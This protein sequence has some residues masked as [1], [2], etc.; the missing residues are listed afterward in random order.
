MESVTDSESG[1]TATLVR[2]M[3][4]SWN[5]GPLML[6]YPTYSGTMFKLGEHGTFSGMVFHAHPSIPSIFINGSNTYFCMGGF[7]PLGT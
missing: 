5:E 7:R 6:S 1:M 2:A 4:D 3:S